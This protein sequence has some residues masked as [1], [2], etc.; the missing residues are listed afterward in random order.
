ML[1]LIIKNGQSYI[2]GKLENKDIAVKDGKIIKIGVISEEAK[3]IY[4]ANN[5]TVLPGCIDTQTHFREPG[6]TDTEDLNSGSR[7]AVAGGITSVFEM[8]NTNPPTSN[9]KEFQRKLDLAKNRMYCNYAFYFGATADNVN[10]LAE[11]K[12]LQG[13][14]GIKL[15]AG[16][17]TGNLLVA[18]E[19]DIDKV[20]KKALKLLQFTQ[21]MKRF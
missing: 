10:Q 11:L 8:P 18:D 7:A 20:F 5:Q 14:C 2:N 13:C 12:N 3:E 17:S 1:D 21:K 9:I 19:K 4:D 16:S 6:S 15:F